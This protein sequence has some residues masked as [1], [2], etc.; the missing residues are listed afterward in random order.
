MDSLI[1]APVAI[2]NFILPS[3]PQ[4]DGLLRTQLKRVGNVIAPVEKT[5]KIIRGMGVQ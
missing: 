5:I 4:R 1:L 3:Y 2:E